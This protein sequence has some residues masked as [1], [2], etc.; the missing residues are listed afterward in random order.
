[1]VTRDAAPP[2]EQR[3]RP[4]VQHEHVEVEPRRRSLLEGVHAVRLLTGV[5]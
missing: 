1:M 2:L 3:F 4:P 5:A